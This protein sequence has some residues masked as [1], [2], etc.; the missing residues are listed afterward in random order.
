M[1]AK[2]NGD[3]HG[4]PSSSEEL[5]LKKKDFRRVRR[6]WR[7]LCLVV[8]TF[9]LQMDISFQSDVST[10]FWAGSAYILVSWIAISRVLGTNFD[11]IAIM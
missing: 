7:Q 11:S 5:H 4:G 3:P 6:L 2:N 1:Q 8:F 9:K 10:R